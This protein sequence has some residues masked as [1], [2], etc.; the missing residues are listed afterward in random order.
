[1][2]NA[3]GFGEHAGGG[4]LAEVALRDF[5]T[6]FLRGV[7]QT[8]GHERRANVGRFGELADFAFPATDENGTAT[9]ARGCFKIGDAV[10]D[11]VAI[12]QRDAHIGCGLLEH[13]DAGFAAVAF[14]AEPGDFCF[15]MMQAVVD[16]IDATTGFADRRENRAFE[17]FQRFAL[18]VSLGDAGLI[19]NDRDTQAEIVEEANGFGNARKKLELSARE[20][21]VDDTSVVMVDE[22]VYHAVAIE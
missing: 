21:S 11:H 4:G 8:L 22:G 7:P 15:G 14:L 2:R 20:W 12:F 10:T 9:G 6:D 5:V 17:E 13:C 19:G 3:S 16:V 1:M 18:E